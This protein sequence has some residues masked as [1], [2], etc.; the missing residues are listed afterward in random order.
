MAQTCS[1]LESNAV[2]VGIDVSKDHLD[3]AQ[4]P[5]GDQIQTANNVKGLRALLR[6]IGRQQAVQVVF[7]ATGPFH[8]QLESQLAKASI[9]FSRINPRHARKF[10]EATGKL[11]KTDRVDAMMLARMGH[12]LNPGR[13]RSAASSSL[14]YRNWQLHDEI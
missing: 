8:R 7:E 12:F 11:A 13:L 1:K 3:A 9:P 5:D 10:A 14:R 2:V 6:W 4:Y